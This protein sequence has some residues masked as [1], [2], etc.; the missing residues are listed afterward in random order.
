MADLLLALARAAVVDPL[1]RPVLEDAIRE[2]GWW[3]DRIRFPLSTPRTVNE[4]REEILA[5]LHWPGETG[6][7]CALVIVHALELPPSVPSMLGPKPMHLAGD[8]KERSE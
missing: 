4:D 1:Y 6:T 5:L 7:D 2:S 8:S 3:D